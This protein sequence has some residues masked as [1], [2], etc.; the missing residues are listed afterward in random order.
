MNSKCFTN[1]NNNKCTFTNNTYNNNSTFSINR[2]KLKE[3]RC[4]K[5][6]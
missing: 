4:F 6:N 3:L 1:S 2:W 5:T